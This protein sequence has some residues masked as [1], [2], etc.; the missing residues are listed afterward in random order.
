MI[1]TKLFS[2][3]STKYR[4]SDKVYESVGITVYTLPA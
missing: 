4:G 1:Q 3:Y 2:L